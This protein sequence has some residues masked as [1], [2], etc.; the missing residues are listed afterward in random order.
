MLSDLASWWEAHQALAS[1]LLALA[2]L[3]ILCWALKRW[4]RPLVVGLLSYLVMLLPVLGIVQ[5]GPQAMAERYTY[6]PGI[7]LAVL[8][9]AAVGV[10]WD[11]AAAASRFWVAAILSIRLD[12]LR[13]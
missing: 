13:G 2:L 8:A 5:V 1:R 4:R 9:G 12:V 3:V 6:L 11:R 10:V 7:A